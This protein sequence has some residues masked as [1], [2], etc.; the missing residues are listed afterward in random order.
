M[1]LKHLYLHGFKTFAP[2][3]ELL[4]G[5]G[6]TA[7]VGPNGSGKSNVA[8][9]VRWVLG[10]QS[11]S[12]LRAKRTE[13]LIFAGS[14]NRSPLGMAEV[15]ITID[16]SD[17]LLPLE[18]SEVT[19]TRRAY[20]S[21]ENEYYINK[22]RVRLRDVLDVASTLGQAYTVVGQGLVDAALSLRPEERREL[23][24]EAAAIRGYFVQRE[25]ALKRLGKT[26]E[27]VAR[28]N[29]LA[30]EL[31]P[32][33]RR[34]ERQARQAQE[35]KKLEEELHELLG[36]WY[37]MRWKTGVESLLRAHRAQDD[38]LAEVEQRKS[39][40]S[41]KMA[42]LGEART[43]VWQLVDA[44]SKLHEKRAQGQARHAAG[45]QAQA[46]LA[47]RLSAARSQR[48][49]L[50]KEKETL[51]SSAGS[52]AE[53]LARFEEEAAQHAQEVTAL[54]ES[55]KDVGR[56]VAEIDALLDE[57][58]AAHIR[59]AGHLD[60]L[61]R[62]RIELQNRIIEAER[63]RAEKER[64]VIE[65]EV[66]LGLLGK[67]VQA[68][69]GLLEEK[70][71]TLTDAQRVVAEAEREQAVARKELAEAHALHATTENE[72]REAIRKLEA[73]TSQ[74]V[75]LAGEQQSSLYGG[76][77]AVVAAASEGRLGG[78]VGTVAEL[79]H[80][81]PDLESAV[82]AALGGRLQEVVVEKWEDAEGAIT[83]LKT[84]GAGRATFL[85]LDTLRSPAAQA[86]PKGSGIIGV[87]RDLMEYEA[88]LQKLA[89]AL[90]G[91]LLIVEDLA[92]A[93]RTLGGMQANAPWT[94][95][96]LS[97]E[98]VRPG[99]SLTGGSHTRGDD[100]R[101][102][103]KTILS[104]ERRRRELL[105]AQESARGAV[106]EREQSV[107]DAM[108]LVREREE[109]VASISNR[110][111]E[112]RKRQVGAQMAHLERQNSVARLHQEYSW[113]N[114]LLSEMRKN[115]DELATSIE[116]MNHQRGEIAGLIEPQQARVAEASGRLSDLEVE[117]EEM[118]RGTSEGQTRLAVLAEALRNVHARM[119]EV[120]REASRIDVS[121]L[122]IERRLAKEE[123]DE[124]EMARRLEE[125][126]AEVAFLAEQLA[127]AE[128]EI[129]HSERQVR[130]LEGEVS[131]I[132]GEQ[133]ALQAALLESETTYSRSAVE[134]QRCV[135]TLDSLRVE[136]I[137]EMAGGSDDRDARVMVEES[138]L[139]DTSAS[140]RWPLAR[141]DGEAHEY[142]E[143]ASLIG[144]DN[145]DRERRIY[146]LKAR[147]S[148]L[149]PVNPLAL[150]EHKALAERHSYLQVQLTDLVSAAESLRRVIAELD[151]T[152]RDQFA[153]TFDQVNDAF[154]H[155][156]NRLFGGGTARLE[157]TNPMDV[158][159]SGVEILAQPPGKRMQPL[160]ALSG[161]ERALTS[162]ALLFALLKV[163]P[164]P[165]CVLDE[166]DAALDE[167][168]VTR[169]RSALQEL[170]QKTQFVVI[171]HNRG[172]IE[173]ADTLDG[174]SMACDGTSQLLSLKV[175]AA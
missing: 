153:A 63:Q 74:L 24:E 35:Y 100:G 175:E 82:E 86:A 162:A 159:A 157:L 55:G 77:R 117:R 104:R 73:L 20:R 90:L 158:S 150:E 154:Q 164:V 106:A 6:L 45:S 66:A 22:S 41:A 93:R 79:I 169:F 34:M 48:Q 111:D 71:H 26:E 114:G 136:I 80:V 113:R 56:R 116:G 99:G 172:T 91:R 51:Q 120:R 92:S 161:G 141:R 167:A 108:A 47:E 4:F 102:K 132:E 30:S 60:G 57:A 112:V 23:F 68:E 103:G 83:M 127:S 143:K 64:A 70:H 28:V 2:R 78:Y 151:R 76:V 155:F 101:A 152:M 27:N 142:N 119:T 69:D 59:E 110:V 53:L 88:R 61:V 36:V 126:A 156:F 170:G 21:G 81:P 19:L 9:A 42:E 140:L 146:A 138:G 149:G 174:I 62:K 166:V 18:F 50:L 125:Q 84:A 118:V 46:V 13:D 173:A 39:A 8:D 94:L 38:A 1:R 115:I 44:V 16:N 37:R 148:R 65:A 7:I 95:A 87:A 31:E 163:R 85:P 14:S 67:K 3:T 133:T 168:N 147:L 54:E 145:S 130:V 32:Q 15:S 29:D 121:L 10:E 109:T 123:V 98:V 122:D 124:A 72:Y 165:F 25:D 144:E 128:T 5:E 139:L 11:L 131:R 171:T 58:R 134:R 52:A 105:N 17:R 12:N 75:A 160:A 89:E 137:E 33:V 107:A 49:A 43:R 97:G 135:G 96:T 129:A 40:M